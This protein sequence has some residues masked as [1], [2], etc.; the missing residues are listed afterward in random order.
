MSSF[1]YTTWGIQGTKD[2]FDFN[3]MLQRAEIKLRIVFFPRENE[4]KVDLN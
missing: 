1:Q 2:M 4:G 3:T